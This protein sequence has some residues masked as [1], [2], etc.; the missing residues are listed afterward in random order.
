MSS[1]GSPLFEKA[2]VTLTNGNVFEIVA[3]GVSK[4]NKYIKSAKFNGKP[5][6]STTITHEDVMKGGCLE[7]E[8]TDIPN[9]AW[10]F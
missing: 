5:W 7:F 10:G 2:R 9:K 6:N 1:I 3:H 4:D 8:M